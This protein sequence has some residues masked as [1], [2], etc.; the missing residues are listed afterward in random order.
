MSVFKYEHSDWTQGFMARVVCVGEGPVDAIL[1]TSQSLNASMVRQRATP[2]HNDRERKK[3]NERER[4]REKRE[5][6]ERE[7]ESNFTDTID[8]VSF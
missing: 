1:T 4:E 2:P 7:R 8:E 3:E 5:E 6:R